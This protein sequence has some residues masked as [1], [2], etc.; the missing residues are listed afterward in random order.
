[1]I[2]INKLTHRLLLNA[3]L[4]TLLEANYATSETITETESHNAPSEDRKPSHICTSAVYLHLVAATCQDE[5]K[6][7]PSCKFS[8]RQWLI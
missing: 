3:I 4:L 7:W 8:S 1:M 2:H 6:E 5:Q